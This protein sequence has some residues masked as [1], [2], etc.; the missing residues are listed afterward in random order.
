VQVRLLHRGRDHDFAAGLARAD[1]E[2]T[3]ETLVPWFSAGKPVAALAA[4]RLAERGEAPLDTPVAE[5]LPDFRRPVHDTVTLRHLL[6]HTSGIRDPGRLPS[7][8]PA[9]IV[10]GA[11][12][13]G[14]RRP[15]HPGQACGYSIYAE[16]YVLSAVLEAVTGEPLGTVLNETLASVGARHSTFGM[17]EEQ[18]RERE[19]AI[20]HLFQRADGTGWA[21]MPALRRSACRCDRAGNALGPVG[22]LARVLA[23]LLP[24]AAGSPVGAATRAAMTRGRAEGTDPHFERHVGYGLG[25]MA[26]V[27][28]AFGG[29]WGA[30]SFG[31]IGA[32]FVGAFADPERDLVAAFF[33]NGRI[34]A[35]SPAANM[36]ATV[37]RFVRAAAAVGAALDVLDAPG[38]RDG[39]AGE[40]PVS[41][42][43]NGPPVLF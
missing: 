2:M 37:P 33:L 29:R 26:D 8:P 15:W 21:R 36:R 1:R 41:W 34:S 3:P 11:A 31:H 20:A 24:D 14:N 40:V 27:R 18:Y 5:W 43:G 13:N 16:W 38:T 22:D 6:T 30:R 28:W 4:V 23:A 32:S 19:G 9:E 35:G 7:A 42:A 10:A 17:A 25:V 12:R 39:R